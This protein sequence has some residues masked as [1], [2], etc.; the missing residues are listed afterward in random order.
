MVDYQFPELQES[1]S[2]SAVRSLLLYFVLCLCTKVP[3]LSNIRPLGTVQKEAVLWAF[4]SCRFCIFQQGPPMYKP[5][6][7]AVIDEE[8]NEIAIFWVADL[9]VYS[10][11][12][13]DVQCTEIDPYADP[14][15]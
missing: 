12:N 1:K 8:G 2:Q 15:A 14:C 5:H 11:W 10:L 3:N 4:E 13:Y 6:I 9:G 7:Q